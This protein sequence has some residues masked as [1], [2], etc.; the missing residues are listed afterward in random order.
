MSFANPE[1]ANID[2]LDAI[3]AA[4]APS[5]TTAFTADTPAGTV[6]GGPITSVDMRQSRDFST[7][8]PATFA[9]GRPKNEVV[10]RVD[11]PDG[12]RA[13]YI[14]TWGRDRNVLSAAVGAAGLSKVSEALRPGNVLTVRFNGKK[15]AATGT[16][17]R[18]EYRDYEYKIEPAP[19]PAA[20]AP[21][22]GKT[23]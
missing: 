10:V 4:F 1:N 11:T 5:A 7:G 16:G 19:A 15:E 9:D 12:E 18:Y 23:N 3:D 14:K 20:V 17:E 2:L 21:S 13:I 8:N 6:V 22:W